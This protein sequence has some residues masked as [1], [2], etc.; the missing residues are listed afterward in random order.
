MARQ[1]ASRIIVIEVAN[2][3]PLQDGPQVWYRFTSAEET[4]GQKESFRQAIS[5]NGRAAR[6]L[7]AVVVR[8]VRAA[9]RATSEISY[10]V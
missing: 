10:G 9:D 8:R 4:D 1:I 6:G 2:A 3:S 7:L 5:L